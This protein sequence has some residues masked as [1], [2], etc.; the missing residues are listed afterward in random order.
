[1]QKFDTFPRNLPPSEVLKFACIG[2]S[3]GFLSG[4]F[5]VGGGSVVVP[6]LLLTTPYTHH[7]ALGTS[8]AAMVPP[9]IFGVAT[10]HANFLKTGTQLVNYRV[11]GAVALGCGVGGWV[12]AK[13]GRKIDEKVSGG[14]EMKET[15]AS[16]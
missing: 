12:G 13:M 9:S 14:S 4:M 11:G 15:G 8:L 5:G 16:R 3:S 1:M 10:H 2:V 7:E 6:A